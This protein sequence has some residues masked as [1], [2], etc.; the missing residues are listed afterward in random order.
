M[1]MGED[2]NA[3]EGKVG[4]DDDEDETED[5][6]ED[7]ADDP[8]DDEAEAEADAEEEEDDAG[9]VLCPVVFLGTGCEGIVAALSRVT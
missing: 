9:V 8:L 2:E 7:A 1:G 3:N 5:E 4:K 6:T